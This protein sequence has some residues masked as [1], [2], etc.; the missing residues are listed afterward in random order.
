M[1]PETYQ[2][3]DIRELNTRREGWWDFIPRSANDP[4]VPSYQWQQAPAR[5]P[6]PILTEEKRLEQKVQAAEERGL[7]LGNLPGM[8]KTQKQATANALG[9]VGSAAVL[10]AMGYPN[11]AAQQAWSGVTGWVEGMMRDQAEK[12]LGVQKVSMPLSVT[13][14]NDADPYDYDRLRTGKKR[15]HITNNPSTKHRYWKYAMVE[16]DEQ[17]PGPIIYNGSGYHSL[18]YN[19]VIPQGKGEGNFTG[20]YLDVHKI[21][22]HMEIFSRRT[23]DTWPAADTAMRI[24]LWYEFNPTAI[25]GESKYTMFSTTDPLDQNR[26]L[27]AEHSIF[28][29]PIQRRENTYLILGDWKVNWRGNSGPTST[30]FQWEKEFPAPL[31]TIPNVPTTG[32]PVAK[33]GG[34]ALQVTA[35]YLNQDPDGPFLQY[36]AHFHVWFTDSHSSK[37]H[38]R[39]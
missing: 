37:K 3:N 8:S 39:D 16:F 19:D 27:L 13:V 35:E 10:S 4:T 31:R 34:W 11:M 38:K 5:I 23:G 15:Q 33:W 1:D 7:N 18:V 24:M 29:T 9:K 26:A 21:M 36:D 22:L 2:L 14:H 32:Q 6:K 17:D 25:A 12:R 30:V 20:D 28:T